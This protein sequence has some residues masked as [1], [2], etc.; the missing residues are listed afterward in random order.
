MYIYIYIWHLRMDPKQ[1][2]R[3]SGP[4]GFQYLDWR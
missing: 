1:T 2:F 3:V 4:F